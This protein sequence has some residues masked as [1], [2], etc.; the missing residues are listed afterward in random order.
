MKMAMVMESCWV[1]RGGGRR[2]GGGGDQ[3]S[4][5]I[6][7]ARDVTMIDGKF[8]RQTSKGGKAERRRRGRSEV[9]RG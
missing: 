6:A 4:R 9:G 5:I 3:K 8:G 1:C 7:A 2:E